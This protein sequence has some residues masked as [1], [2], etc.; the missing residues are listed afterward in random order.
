MYFGTSFL[1]R[2]LQFCAI[3][4][5]HSASCNLTYR[6]R[7]KRLEVALMNLPQTLLINRKILSWWT[8]NWSPILIPIVG[9]DQ[10]LSFLYLLIYVR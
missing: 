8:A 5:S 7:K 3:N 1:E 6:Y 10:G 4:T 9:P 2:G